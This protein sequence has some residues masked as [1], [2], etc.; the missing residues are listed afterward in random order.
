MPLIKSKSKKAFSKNVASE[1]ESGKP[2]GQSL[3]IAYDVQRRA[4]KPKKMAK[5]GIVESQEEVHPAELMDDE[6]RA[7]SVAAAIMQRRRAKKMAEGGQVDLEANNEE[8]PSSLDELNV[9][10]VTKE[11]D[12]APILKENYEKED[13]ISKIRKNL[14]ARKTY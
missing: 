13:M 5:G 12:S 11:V 10:S 6:E 9:M 4:G 3:A 14:K 2:Q 7:E 1:M 8:G